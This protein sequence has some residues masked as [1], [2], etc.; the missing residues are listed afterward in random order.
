MLKNSTSKS[1]HETAGEEFKA[2]RK[3][4]GMTQVQ[5]AA[6]LGVSRATVVGWEKSKEP[7]LGRMVYLGL[8]AL[9]RLEDTR[10][11]THPSDGHPRKAL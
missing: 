5:I 1:K 2:A 8:Q 10:L 9:L 4:L 3:E 7:Y 11:L 6:E